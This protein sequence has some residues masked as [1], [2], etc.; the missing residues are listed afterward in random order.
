[1]NLDPLQSFEARLFDA[2]RE[3]VLPEGAEERVVVAARKR[4]ASA[5]TLPLTAGR[6]AV[7]L[8]LAAAVLSVV[9]VF[10]RR[11][12]PTFAITAE[13][14]HRGQVEA[15][16]PPPAEPASAAV[17]PGPPREVQPREA[18]PR[19]PSARP[20]LPATLADELAALKRAESA[21]ASGDAASALAELDRYDGV[22]RGRQMRAEAA[23]LRMEALSR[24]GKTDAAS[25]LALRFVRDN[26]E[27]PLVDRAR[28]FLIK[29]SGETQEGS[30]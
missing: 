28:S 12:E 29:K 7:W 19:A 11:K 8:L 14:S 23:L 13:P 26:P 18:P 6:A 25:T 21:L 17:H 24:A 30:P 27:S 5:R 3:E 1:M 10:I 9:T 16:R 4:R 20:A 15:P 2:A 22:L